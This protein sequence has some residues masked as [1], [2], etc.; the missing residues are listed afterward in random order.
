MKPQN[1]PML[2]DDVW[3]R[4]KKDLIDLLSPMGAKFQGY[5]GGFNH[6]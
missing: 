3:E 2:P 4:V 6:N 5:V 1:K